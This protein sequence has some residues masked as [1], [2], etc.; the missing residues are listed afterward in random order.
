MNLHDSGGSSADMD[1]IIATANDLFAYGQYVSSGAQRSLSLL[2]AI[3]KTVAAVGTI[4]AELRAFTDGMRALNE[5]LPGIPESID[6]IR[7]VA[8]LGDAQDAL[9]KLHLLLSQKLS[10]ATSAPELRDHDG[11]ADCY[12]SV[13]EV[14]SGLHDEIEALRWNIMQHN[15]DMDHSD[16]GPGR[17]SPEDITRFLSTL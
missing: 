11:I 6:E 13:L 8:V 3:E 5:S 1:A 9:A 2:R 16:P 17:S 15:A 7:T 14:A 12:R 10:A 4:R